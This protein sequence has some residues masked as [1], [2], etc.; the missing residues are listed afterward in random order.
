MKHLKSVKFLLIRILFG[1]VIYRH[2]SS[3]RCYQ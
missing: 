2:C 1:L 3:C